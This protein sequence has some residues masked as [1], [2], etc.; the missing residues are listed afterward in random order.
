MRKIRQRAALMIVH[1]AILILI[2]ASLVEVIKTIA[3]IIGDLEKDNEIL[4]AGAFVAA[5]VPSG[6]MLFWGCYA[7]AARLNLPFQMVCRYFRNQRNI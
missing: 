5:L 6:A 7:I 2:L 3:D 4:L 1:C